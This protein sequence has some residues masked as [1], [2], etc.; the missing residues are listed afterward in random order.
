M[1]GG[2]QQS[3][4]TDQHDKHGGEMAPLH[5]AAQNADDPLVDQPEAENVDHH[6]QHD[7]RQTPEP[8]AT[9]IAHAGVTWA[10]N[11]Q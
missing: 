7:Q 2:R 5:G 11:T 1:Q 3:R 10:A 4:G 6:V 9:P 8:V